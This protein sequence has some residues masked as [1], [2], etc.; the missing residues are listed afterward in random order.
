MPGSLFTLNLKEFVGGRNTSVNELLIKD[1]QSA[2][3]LNIKSRPVGALARRDGSIRHYP[4]NFGDYPAIP[5]GLHKLYRSR[6][7]NHVEYVYVAPNLW[8][9]YPSGVRAIVRNDFSGGTF[10]EFASMKDQ[11]YGTNYADLPFRAFGTEIHD[12]EL[13]VPIVPHYYISLPPPVGGAGAYVEELATVAGTGIEL[14]KDPDPSSKIG[15]G[16]W[17]YRFRAYYGKDLGESAFGRWTRYGLRA[18]I[19][20]QEQI[21]ETFWYGEVVS[22]TSVEDRY[23]QLLALSDIV[24]P[25][26]ATKL[27]IYR[28]QKLIE[29]DDTYGVSLIN[30][31]MITRLSKEQ[32]L[33]Q[34]Y[35]LLD[36][37]EPPLPAIYRD[38][39]SDDDLGQ[40]ADQN[41]IR[42]QYARYVAEHNNRL[43]YAN[44]NERWSERATPKELD[45]DGL[46]D[47]WGTDPIHQTSFGTIGWFTVG[48]IAPSR[49]YFTFPY[50][51]SRMEA[52]ID[53][54]P[55][56]GDTIQN[57][58][59]L[60]PILVIL[61]KRH[62]YALLGVDFN[63]FVVRLVDDTVGTI[64]P[65]SVQKHRGS[66]YFYSGLSVY[67]TDGGTVQEVGQNIRFE[68][69]AIPVASKPYASA[70]VHEDDY[71]LAV[72]E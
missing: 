34:P 71:I 16:A 70:G 46:A 72:G 15:V 19:P 41:P 1:N 59:S 63:D 50:E 30:S 51:P 54:R 62:V 18:G 65:L 29:I 5:T 11:A 64:A 26:G 37:V 31:T 6:D 69:A 44:I 55:E 43:F 25:A 56:D 33:N 39:K 58:V 48:P 42:H 67:R 23:A 32:I 66:V 3:E 36:E 61:K 22:A 10:C 27:R 49:L 47:T 53:V 24:L 68:L 7:T 57:I 4:L 21:E 38:K 8:A 2:D 28:T 35:Y 60:G 12:A 40:L 14:G 13:P 45:S 52:F 20:N 17:S 9:V